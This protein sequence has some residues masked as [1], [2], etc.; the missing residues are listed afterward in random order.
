M[1]KI[2]ANDIDKQI[3]QRIQNRRKEKGIT[4]EQ[5][6]EKIKVSQQQ[7]SRYERASNKIP[8]S[9]LIEISKILDT[10]I[11]WFLMDLDQENNN[12][13]DEVIKFKSKELKDKFDFIWDLLCYEEKKALVSLM[14]LIRKK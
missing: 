6:S 8:L 1:S 11:S 4:A 9:H 14:E 5:L 12:T 3:G 2:K 10:P 13:D 7:L